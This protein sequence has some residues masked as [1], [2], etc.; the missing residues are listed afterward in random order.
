VGNASGSN[1]SDS[2]PSRE[3]KPIRKTRPVEEQANSLAW[4]E[5]QYNGHRKAE[6]GLSAQA[7]LRP[8]CGSNTNTTWQSSTTP[9]RPPE[10]WREE[11][12]SIQQATQFML[13]AYQSKIDLMNQVADARLLER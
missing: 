12:Q 13:A 5:R 2:L 7:P 10:T 9:S 3:I 8:R 11:P 6:R 1:Q 4:Q